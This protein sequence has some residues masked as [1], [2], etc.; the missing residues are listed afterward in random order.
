MS[1]MDREGDSEE[2][3]SDTTGAGIEVVTGDKG[4]FTSPG[5][6]KRYRRVDMVRGE[7]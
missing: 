7:G 1:A 6:D 4:T 5:G 3:K 2:G